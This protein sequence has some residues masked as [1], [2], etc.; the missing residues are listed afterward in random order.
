LFSNFCSFNLSELLSDHDW[1]DC[2]AAKTKHLTH[3][4]KDIHSVCWTRKWT[5]DTVGLITRDVRI[6]IRE[7]GIRRNRLT[8][9]G[10]NYFY[11]LQTYVQNVSSNNMSFPI[12]S[13]SN[14]T[15]NTSS[16]QGIFALNPWHINGHLCSQSMTS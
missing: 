15:D 3:V 7:C 6:S 5:T 2:F 11:W 1:W 16:F 14:Q 13:L 9:K 12:S 4:F 8:I 10:I